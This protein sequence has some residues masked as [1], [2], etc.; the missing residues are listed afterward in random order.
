MGVKIAVGKTLGM[1][2]MAGE[3]DFQ[4]LVV[5]LNYQYMYFQKKN[6]L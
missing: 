2:A 5:S 4:D 3:C 6:M 1:L